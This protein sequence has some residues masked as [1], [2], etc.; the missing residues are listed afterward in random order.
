MRKFPV[1]VRI[2]RLSLTV[3]LQIGQSHHHALTVCSG[4][5]PAPSLTLLFN[6]VTRLMQI[7]TLNYRLWIVPTADSAHRTIE[8]RR[9]LCSDVVHWKGFRVVN[10]TLVLFLCRRR[11][12]ASFDDSQLGSSR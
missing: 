9:H 10:S 5:I 4:S 2:F 12:Y 6:I 3:I 11:R 8:F 1:R 7:R